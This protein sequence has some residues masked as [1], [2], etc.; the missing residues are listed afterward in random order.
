MIYL[1]IFDTNDDYD[2]FK[3]G[4]EWITP[5]VSVIVDTLDVKYHNVL[6][7][8]LTFKAIEDSTIALKAKTSPNVLYSIDNGEWVNWD[9]SAITLSAGSFVRM[10]GSNPNGFNSGVE[11]SNYNMFVMTGK[12]SASG[13]IMSLLYDDD[14]EN[15]TTIPCSYCYYCM[16][17]ACTS[18]TSAPELPATILADSCY[19][20]MFNNCTSL[21]ST[22]ELP[23]TTLAKGC[24]EGMFGRCSSLTNAP[25]LPA[26]TLAEECYGYMFHSCTSLTTAPELPAT[27]LAEYCYASMF[28]GCSSL[29]NAPELPATTLAVYCYSSMFNSCT[30]LTAAPELPA[31]TL[32]MYCYYRMF[33]RCSSL[34]NAPELPATTLAKGCYREMFEGCS[35]LNYIKMLATDISASNCLNS[36]VSS[37]ASTGTFVKS[38][39]MISLPTGVNGI[40]SGWTIENV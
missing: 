20:G 6:K 31:T 23:A 8:Y 28:E 40:P 2:S 15:N 21:E 33:E 5:N 19:A 36:W 32:A 39:S 22:P 38:S 30:S 26:T 13:N 17:E 27:T 24:Y 3:N 34:T 18:L 14:F 12:I 11:E 16:F 10:K 25:E 35:K 29:T 4:E 7:N 37:V 1:R 9:Y